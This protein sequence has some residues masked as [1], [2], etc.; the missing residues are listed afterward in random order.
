[1]FLTQIISSNRKSMIHLKRPPFSMSFFPH[2]LTFLSLYFSLYCSFSFFFLLIRYF[3]LL[4]DF[5][6]RVEQRLSEFIQR[7]QQLSE[8]KKSLC[9]LHLFTYELNQ[10]RK[11]RLSGA[12]ENGEPKTHA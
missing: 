8:K 3:V 4:L 1:M 11:K 10:C 9:K 12:A 5:E 7:N 2:S 6:N